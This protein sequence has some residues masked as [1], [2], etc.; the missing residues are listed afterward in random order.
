[1][2]PFE[3]VSQKLMVAPGTAGESVRGSGSGSRQPASKAATPTRL[4][5]EIL[6][7]DGFAGFY[8]V[9]S[10]SWQTECTRTRGPALCIP[11]AVCVLQPFLQQ[12]HMRHHTP[13]LV[14]DMLCLLNFDTG[15]AFDRGRHVTR[16]AIGPR[17][18]HSHQH[19][20]YGGPLTAQSDGANLAATAGGPLR[21]AR[22]PA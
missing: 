21:Q 22:W 11:D 2:V 4:A 17:C 5:R 13:L 15:L 14:T 3:I 19:Q 20:G 8:K 18:L 12:L 1:M 6:R 9:S 16:R 10:P 7:A